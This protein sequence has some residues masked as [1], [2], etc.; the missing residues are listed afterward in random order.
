MLKYACSKWFAET[1]ADPSFLRSG[2]ESIQWERQEQR[3]RCREHGCND[4][5]DYIDAVKQR[6][7]RP[8]IPQ[9]KRI[10]LL[11]AATAKVNAAKS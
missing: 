9:R 2:W 8:R 11:E 10:Q 7:S 4:F 5:S 6:P 3:H 1:E